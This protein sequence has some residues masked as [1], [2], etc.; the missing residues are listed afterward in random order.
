M[1]TSLSIKVHHRHLCEAFRKILSPW[2]RMTQARATAIVA[3]NGRRDEKYDL[4][5][6][7]L[8]HYGGNTTKWPPT[9]RTEFPPESIIGIYLKLPPDL[10]TLPSLPTRL[11][12]DEAQ[13]VL[14]DPGRKARRKTQ[15]DRESRA[16]REIHSI[17]WTEAR[18]FM[19]N[20]GGQIRN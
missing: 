9:S 2:S 5:P 20:M 19:I 4:F 1:H 16:E 15:R 6:L 18:V 10:L 11:H 12:S 3:I 14:L 7:P 17:W 8:W 13:Q